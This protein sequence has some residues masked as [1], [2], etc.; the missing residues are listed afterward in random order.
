MKT[1][2]QNLILAIL[3]TISVAQIE[4]S[5]KIVD[6]NNVPLQMTEVYLTA[7]DNTSLKNTYTNEDGFFAITEQK[8]KFDLEVVKDEKVLLKK[9]LILNEN[10]NIGTLVLNNIENISQEKISISKESWYVIKGRIIDKNNQPLPSL[11][12]K[13]T[14]TTSSKKV[15]SNDLGEFELIEKK[16]NYTLKIQQNSKTIFKRKIVVEGNLLL[17]DISI[18]VNKM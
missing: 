7:S 6:K 11:K 4:I 5:G 18:E 9:K 16:G 1:I 17:G 3:P 13:L 10:V 14:S 8:G 15:Y 2:K 12:I